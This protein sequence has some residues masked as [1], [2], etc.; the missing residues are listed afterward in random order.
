MKTAGMF[1]LRLIWNLLRLIWAI[2]QAA[3]VL[4]FIVLRLIW[5]LL[6]VTFRGHFG[7]VMA[8]FLGSIIV[9]TIVGVV[10]ALLIGRFIGV[11][12]Y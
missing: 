3:G 6:E 12:F 7:K 1:I 2:V 4:I 8:L 10:A 11:L 9:L 5:Q